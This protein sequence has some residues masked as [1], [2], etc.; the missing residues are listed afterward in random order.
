VREKFKMLLSGWKRKQL[1]AAIVIIEDEEE[2]M[3][4]RR[5]RTIWVQELFL[6]RKTSGFFKSFQTIFRSNSPDR[7]KD[8]LRMRPNDFDFILERVMPYIQRQDT[9]LGISC[10]ERTCVANSSSTMKNKFSSLI[11]PFP[12]NN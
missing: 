10:G 6:E 1:A 12:L 9:K 4:K 11:F 5:K 7:F 8:F 3:K 2:A